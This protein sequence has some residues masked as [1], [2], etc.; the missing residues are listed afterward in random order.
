MK[1]EEVLLPVAVR[2]SKTPEPKLNFI[3]GNE[4]IAHSVQ[5]EFSGQNVFF[6]V[7]IFCLE[8]PSR[9]SEKVTCHF[10]NCRFSFRK[11]QILISFRFANYS[12]PMHSFICLSVIKFSHPFF[13]LKGRC[14]HICATTFQGIVLNSIRKTYYF[15]LKRVCLK[16]SYMYNL[17]V[18][19]NTEQVYVHQNS[20]NPKCQEMNFIYCFIQS[21]ML[22]LYKEAS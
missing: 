11:L 1:R 21:T 22:G 10:V 3:C 7:A 5:S 18:W 15:E 19:T 8:Y 13:L 14:H 16:A 2:R 9:C 4:N 12:K 17:F 20:C 6:L